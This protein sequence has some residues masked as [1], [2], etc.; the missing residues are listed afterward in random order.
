MIK[1]KDNLSI[2]YRHVND[3]LEK[4]MSYYKIVIFFSDNGSVTESEIRE[5]RGENSENDPLVFETKNELMSFAY[6]S[7]I[8]FKIGHLFVLSNTDY[9]IG[10]DSTQDS[11][12][13]KEIFQRFGTEVK[14]S[15][16]D[17]KESKGFL[18]KFF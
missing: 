18:G 11:S 9:N 3:D 7:L 13:M 16:D 14:L 5:I 4:R 15:S 1:H 12:G 8:H 2:L 10:I 6:S 17:E